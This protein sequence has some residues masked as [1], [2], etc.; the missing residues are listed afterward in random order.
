MLQKGSKPKS[1]DGS[2]LRAVIYFKGVDFMKYAIGLDCGISSVGYSVT[3]LDCHDEPCRIIKL[4]SRIFNAAENPKDGSSLALPRREARGSRRRLRRHRHR[5][6]RIRHLI[7]ENNILSESELEGL[8]KGQLSD[9]YM[10]RTKALDE[11]I[12]NQE[13]ARI[14]INLAQRRG[15]KSNRKADSS[16]KEAGKLLNAVNEN[17]IR[18]EQKSYRTVGEMFY[19]DEKY[20]QYKRNKGED[21]TNTVSRSMIED[22][23]RLIFKAQR[24]LGN[25]N[26]TEEIE[27]KYLEILLS[28]RPFDLGPGV[29]NEKSP[30]P[31]AGEQIL[32]MIG[33]C[34][35]IPSEKRA[36]KASY[37]FQL[38][39]LW[40][41]INNLS[42]INE[43]GEKTF[44]ND[45]QRLAVYNLCHKTP[46]VT[47]EK[48]RK[49]LSVD[50]RLMF[51]SLSYGSKEIE[52]VEKKAK[53]NYLDC[54]HQIRVA[55]NKVKK[56]CIKSLSVD[57]LDKIG[58][59]FTVYKNDEAIISHLKE[60]EIDEL[61]YDSLLTLKG[62]SKFGHISVKACKQILPFLEKGFSYDKACEAA[63]LNFKGHSA[64]EKSVL[65]PSTSE[66]L[67]DITNPVVRR[68]ISQTIKVINA[69]I[70]EQGESPVYIN[71][72]LARELS[73]TFEER[74]KIKKSNDENREKNEAIIQRLK[75]DFSV[76]N[77]TGMDIIKLKLWLEQ[78]GICPYS[79]QPIK[80]D[81]LF[82]T[83]Y[84][85][86]DHIIPYSISFDDSFNNK[87]LTFSRE[88]RQKGNKIPMKY[89]Q[90]KDRDN[91]VV[92]VENNVKNRKKKQNL[93]KADIS[94][95][96]FE[97][98]KERNLNDTRY[99]N[100]VLLNY[101]NDHLLFAPFEDKSRKKH[102][103]SVNGNVTAYVRKRWGII[104]TRENGD[105][106]HAVDAAVISCITDREIQRVSCYSKQNETKY[107]DIYDYESYEINTDTGEIY[108]KF[109]LPYPEFRTEIDLRLRKDP[110]YWL[111]QQP[112]SN[113]SD[114]DIEGVTP[115]FIS[116]MPN[117]KITGPA[118]QDTIRSG[119]ESGF[120]IS[121]VPLSKLKLENGEIPGYYSPESDTLL[122]FALKK[123]LEQFGGSGEKAFPK[124]FEFHKPKSDGSEGPIVKK[125]KIIEKATKSVNV[126]NGIADNGKM[127]RI[128]VF[129]I[130]N[131]G[132]Y[133]VPIYVAD[134][135]NKA[136][137]N[138]ACVAGGREWKPME[139]KDFVFSLYQNDLIK[140]TAKKDY[141]L[142]LKNKNSTLPKE[143]FGNEMLLYYIG[144]DISN[145][146][147][148]V[149]SDDGAY[150]MRGLG[151]KT[152][153]KIE[154]YTVDILGN[155]SK[156]KKENRLSFNK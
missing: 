154:K 77:P 122:Y 139:D 35:L 131:D 134:T 15:F 97:G 142:S 80:A 24:E 114:E 107:T 86:V 48:I 19:L 64:K 137:P 67:E 26:A 53:F 38:F 60:A 136:L 57:E 147:I 108:S 145:G 3:E 127:V 68:A 87:V 6:E 105:L 21:Y 56:D 103:T 104:K 156:V 25:A 51:T 37:S 138:L 39:S 76:H 140:I 89:L 12:S 101:I 14:L 99:L 146:A 42:F 150:L 115:V 69:I 120:K 155:T 94:K 71:I 22:E 100:R 93:L 75:E 123:R 98:F 11:K 133:F 143:V 83:G 18:M 55:L 153:R 119:K 63:G 148:S 85:E 65:L 112:L 10:L 50:D 113:Y 129:Y 45:D 90:G 72:E 70:R 106:H 29:G 92:W 110:K 95:S 49:E 132:Y 109:P 135:I 5:L 144:A 8:F 23:A 91:F 79:L 78:D 7:I 52:E 151:I 66:E 20:S 28:Q 36:A 32:K 44:L 40:Q 128:D 62:F 30:S 27:D 41:N 88:N 111:K 117:R 2:H 141:K 84:V 124:D 73:K 13:F 125:V 96:D 74:K 81:M 31:Y 43:A 118:H 130:E 16:D 152:L 9:I 46:N 102:V 149:E 126:G 33:K 47:F 4:S 61:L 58:Y 17:Q 54:Y 59:I 116:R 121:K 34:T 1:T 82:S